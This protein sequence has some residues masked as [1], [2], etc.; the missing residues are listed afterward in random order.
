MIF[1]PNCHNERGKPTETKIAARTGGFLGAVT[2]PA[3]F[4]VPALF[5]WRDVSPKWKRKKRAGGRDSRSREEGARIRWKG[6]YEELGQR[7]FLKISV[8]KN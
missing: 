3:P 1:F 4:F 5:R 2:Y 7:E 8:L 6:G